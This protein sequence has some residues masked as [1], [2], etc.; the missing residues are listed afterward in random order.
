MYFAF[1]CVMILVWLH[2]IASFEQTVFNLNSVSYANFNILVFSFNFREKLNRHECFP[3]SN[4]LKFFCL[5]LSLKRENVTNGNF[6]SLVENLKQFPQKM[7]R[8]LW[9]IWKQLCL[10]VFQGRRQQAGHNKTKKR[11]E[12]VNV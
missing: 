1:K 4:F 6:I 2:S 3:K 12:C 10:S 5:T 8:N 11:R 7:L 9:K